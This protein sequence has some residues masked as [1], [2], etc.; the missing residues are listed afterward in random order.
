MRS[1]HGAARRRATSAPATARDVDAEDIVRAMV[2]RDLPPRAGAGAAPA[3]AGD[4]AAPSVAA[5][6]RRPCF[7]DVSLTVRAG[8][9]V[10]L[11]GLVGSGRSELLET[12]F[13]LHAPD[14]GTIARR[15][16]SRPLLARRARRRAAGIALVPEER[17]RQGLSST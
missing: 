1:H 3:A 4:A 15:R 9:I 5:S 11:F 16:P 7:D 8:E 12:I 6:T 2:G 14:A 13:G 17:Q 10:G